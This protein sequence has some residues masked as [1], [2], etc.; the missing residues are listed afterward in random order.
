MDLFGTYVIIPLAYKI[1][2][3]HHIK[4]WSNLKCLK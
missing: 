4:I 3:E 1:F 2:V